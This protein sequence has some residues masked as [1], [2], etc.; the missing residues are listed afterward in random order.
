MELE[1]RKP[2]L[3]E[4][5]KL[6]KFLTLVKHDYVPPFSDEEKI[7]ELNDIRK[8]KTKAII[9]ITAEAQIVG[10][11]SWKPYDKDKN[12]G[13]MANI[14]VHPQ[15]RR[16]G[17]STKLRELAFEEMEKTGF[18][19]VYYTT[20]HTNTAMVESSR[21]LGMTVVKVYLDE[22]FRGTGGKTIL[23]RKKF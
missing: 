21:K 15:W 10:Y 8:E 22:G 3:P 11:V 13:Y 23:Y 9:A 7:Q 16:K 6:G 12:Y 20:W 5:A 1:F 2:T 18:R 14:A 19:G 4:M 17:I